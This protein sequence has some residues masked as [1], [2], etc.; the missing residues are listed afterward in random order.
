MKKL[1]FSTILG[2]V[3]LTFT[4]CGDDYKAKTKKSEAPEMKCEAGKCGK[5]KCGRE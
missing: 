5:G 3:V 2:L 1:L 4:G